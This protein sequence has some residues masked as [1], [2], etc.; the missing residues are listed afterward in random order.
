MADITVRAPDAEVIRDAVMLAS[1]AP[2][3][4]NSQPWRWIVEHAGLQ[5]WADP[6]RLVPATDHTGRELLLSCG[7][8]L[9]HLR[10][11]M[12]AA[13]WECATERLPDPSLPNHLATLR[14]HALDAVSEQHRRRAAAIG[15]RRT[16]RLPFGAPAGWPALHSALRCAVMPFNVLLD[17]VPDDD[18][19][20]LAEESALI[21]SLRRYDTTYLSELRWWTSPFESDE[22]HVPQTSLVSSS[23]AARVDVSRR[24]PPVGGGHR[25]T[26]VDHDCSK[27]V[28][29]STR[30]G[31]APLDVLRCG[32]ALSAVL[33][34]CT[35][36][37]A[38]TCTLTHMTEIEQSRR[39]V[40]SIVGTT[41]APQ[42]LIRVGSAPPG[43]QHVE[44][45]SRR[46]VTEVLEFRE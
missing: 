4:H 20:R 19:P 11:A 2:S 34:E 7:A 42:L 24:F 36:A 46:L 41:G 14:F 29:L 1:R 5:L 25:R 13:G 35:M 40:T 22:T 33:L 10:V 12:A 21:E 30:H 39:I 23:E 8:V 3:L 28:V 6:C 9:D 38:A 37:G 45:T 32:E 26:A 16:D 15:R 31:D 43:G 18:R 27:I 17:V 44:A